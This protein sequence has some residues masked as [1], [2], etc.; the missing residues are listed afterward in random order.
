M[1]F[2]SRGTEIPIKRVSRETKQHLSLKHQNTNFAKC[3]RIMML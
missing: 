1:K 3:L 2:V